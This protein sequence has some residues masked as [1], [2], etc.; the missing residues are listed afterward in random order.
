V[1]AEA[2]LGRGDTAA[3]VR[4]AQH[5]LYAQK[6]SRAFSVVARARCRQGDI[7]SARA[8]LTRVSKSDRPAVLRDCAAVGMDLR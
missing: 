5:S 8:A 1:E 6:S 3:A 2:A 7:G 4:L